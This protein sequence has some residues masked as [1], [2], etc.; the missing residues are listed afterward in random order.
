MA[1]ARSGRGTTG[2]GEQWTPRRAVGAAGIGLPGAVAASRPRDVSTVAADRSAVDFLPTWMAGSSFAAVPGHPFANLVH[3]APVYATRSKAVDWENVHER[4]TTAAAEFDYDAVTLATPPWEQGTSLAT[5]GGDSVLPIP[6]NMFADLV[7]LSKSDWTTSGDD[8]GFLG[9]G[10]G[11]SIT[12]NDLVDARRDATALRRNNSDTDARQR[13]M[14]LVGRFETT[15]IY[16]RLLVAWGAT[17]AVPVHRLVVFLELRRVWR[18]LVRACHFN[19]CTSDVA[20]A[21]AIGATGMNGCVLQVGMPPVLMNVARLGAWNKS[22]DASINQGQFIIQRKHN[23][24]RATCHV[25][26]LNGEP[27]VMFYSKRGHLGMEVGTLRANIPHLARDISASLMA[28]HTAPGVI[29]DGEIVQIDA[30]GA[31]R[32]YA[33]S[34][35]AGMRGSTQSVFYAFD[36]LVHG[37]TDV[38][39]QPANARYRI[40]LDDLGALPDTGALRLS[41]N[42]HSAVSNADAVKTL[43]MDRNWEGLIARR[44]VSMYTGGRSVH[45]LLRFVTRGIVCVEFRRVVTFVGDYVGGWAVL[46]DRSEATVFASIDVLVT[47]ANK[48]DGLWLDPSTG[49]VLSGPPTGHPAY[50]NKQEVVDCTKQL[51][52]QFGGDPRVPPN[53]IHVCINNGEITD[54][55]VHSV[56]GEPPGAPWER[57]T[58]L[59]ANQKNGRGRPRLVGNSDWAKLG[60]TLVVV[61]TQPADGDTYIKV[62]RSKATTL[63]PAT[64]LD[65]SVPISSGTAALARHVPRATSGYVRAASQ[66]TQQGIAEYYVATQTGIDTRVYGVAL[67]S[68]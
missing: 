7:G 15:D 49:T 23:G 59:R 28:N 40:L 35:S 43:A 53:H 14:S 56:A 50:L 51:R 12:L 61:S 52:E 46:G 17:G 57:V 32:G 3:A 39:T 54:A 63:D 5:S 68:P 37:G 36:V 47:L 55:A 4:L 64:I 29:Y 25:Y 10:A 8:I 21:C 11:S 60:P 19:A 9:R 45:D 62:M 24:Q 27:R 2:G 38:Q 13:L 42:L 31:E 1:R 66:F 18:G 58:E 65:L 22:I 41:R 30:T 67:P 44:G 26:E 6:T 33:G 34:A 20:L 48:T 16:N